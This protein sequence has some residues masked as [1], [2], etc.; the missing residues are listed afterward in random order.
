M[1]RGTISI[2]ESCKQKKPLFVKGSCRKCY[3]KKHKEKILK[4]HREWDRRNP[5]KKKESSNNF[6]FGGNRE[7]ALER[8]NWTCQ[9]CGMSQEKC[10][11]M[12]NR[13]LSIHHKDENGLNVSKE[14]KNNDLDNLIT[15]CTRCHNL[16][17]RKINKERLFGDL[18]EQ[19]GSVYKYPKV[20]ELL[21]KKKEKLGTITKAKNEF[22]E[23]MG[24]TYHAVDHMHYQRKTTPFH[25][26]VTE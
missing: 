20:R 13:Q 6:H 7:L 5:H 4:N 12:F 15:I 23:E 21:L 1:I 2:C 22:A 9:E 14:E 8:D 3:D 18:L 19:D 24:L 26:K 16:L 10:I 25:G 17:H 11:V